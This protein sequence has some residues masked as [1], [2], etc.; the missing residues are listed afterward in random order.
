M[1]DLCHHELETGCF[2]YSFEDSP[3]E[4]PVAFSQQADVE[5]QQFKE[6][7]QLHVSIMTTMNNMMTILNQVST[8]SLI[9]LKFHIKNIMNFLW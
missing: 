1:V 4:K 9:V 2:I 5:F 6:S 3:R 8:H 7:N